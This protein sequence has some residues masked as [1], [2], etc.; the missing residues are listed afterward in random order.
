MVL[1]SADRQQRERQ[2]AF[3]RFSSTPRCTEEKSIIWRE[4]GF[5]VFQ[6]K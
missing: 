4:M 6:L 5:E 2:A 3:F 1:G